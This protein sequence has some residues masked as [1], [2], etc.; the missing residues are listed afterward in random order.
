MTVRTIY[1]DPGR[2]AKSL[3]DMIPTRVLVKNRMQPL[4]I[5]WVVMIVIVA[6][7][8]ATAAGSDTAKPV[9]N[10]TLTPEETKWIEDH[11]FIRVSGPRAFPPFHFFEK[12]GALKGISADYLFLIM[13][14]LGIAVVAT[15][16]LPWPEVLEKARLKQIDLIACAAR[17]PE[18]E[19]YLNFSDSYLSF[20]LVIVSRKD[21]EFIG[22]IE[23]LYGKTLAVVQKNAVIEWLRQDGVKYL[24]YS[25]ST[26]LNGLEAVAF[27]RADA[28]IEN[29]AAASFLIEKHGL[30]NLKIAAPTPYGPYDLHMAVREDAPVLLGLINKALRSIPPE[31]RIQ[32][33][34]KW[35]SVRY[36][37]GTSRSEVFGWIA[38]ILIFSVSLLCLV[39]IWRRQLGQESLN[40]RKTEAALRNSEQNLLVSKQKLDLHFKHTPLAVIE[41]DLDFRVSSWNPAAEK[42]FGYSESQILG[43]QAA[44]LVHDEDKLIVDDVWSALLEQSGGSRSTNR[45]VTKQ[46][47]TIICE[48]FNAPVVDENGEIIAVFSL[49]LNVTRRKKAEQALE[50]TQ[51]LFKMITDH[52]S[53][54]VSIHDANGRFVYASPSFSRIGHDPG[55]L[56]GRSGFDIMVKEDI[57]AILNDMDV[58]RKD[59][60]NQTFLD[61]RLMDS[62][63][64]THYYRGAF[65]AVYDA[66]SNLEKIIC[67]GED[68]TELRTVQS[69]KVQALTLAAETNKYALVGQVAGKMAHDFNNILSAIMGNAELALLDSK[70][71]EM[72]ETFELILEQTMRGRNLT[73]NLVAF[74]KD[75]E[76]KQELFNLNDKI[77][78]V[79]SLMKKDLEGIKVVLKTRP[80]LPELLA[81]PGMIEHALVNILQNAIHAVSLS[82]DPR[83]VIRT[84]CE[85]DTVMII[86]EDNGC[87]I[88][89]KYL[90]AIFE[91]SFSLKGNKDISGVYE[92]RIKGTGYG[93]ANVKKYIEQHH[94]RIMVRSSLDSGTAFTIYLPIIKEALTIEEKQQIQENR[95]VCGR[96]ILI[97]EDEK[98]ISDIQRRTLSQSPCSH[99]VDVASDGRKAIALFDQGAYDLVS[100]DYILPGKVNGM[101]VY[102]HIR[103]TDKRL[104]V[105][106][107]SGNIE[108][109]ESI[110]EMKRNDSRIDHLSKPCQNKIYVNRISQMLERMSEKG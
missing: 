62:A 109:L 45:N 93:L 51:D 40:R 64:H 19:A 28:R 54:L 58:I 25:V 43:R 104:P 21:S 103:K 50:K 110:K 98:A 107:I 20:P 16:A 31:T 60:V 106:F 75:Q 61:Y 57:E 39:L 14:Q 63:G 34:S 74:A 48:W 95:P 29:L 41:W 5:F 59:Q 99:Q 9:L 17:V 13:E 55:E 80:D 23:D 90:Y 76:I 49:V 70:D 89:E 53:A 86:V 3:N 77:N 4:L 91:P 35:L 100:L 12:N 72:S 15:G 97:V 30:T 7:F 108:F 65:D 22:G 66:R 105:L 42:I 11:P 84:A 26:P 1:R 101:D 85:D 67:V 102:H 56:I 2:I 37:K 52:T 83:I 36:E 6:G 92:E 96:R 73:K 33:R 79:I 71:S 88:E 8:G 81:D 68:I 38:G 24:P 69:E 82:E 18:R 27:G 78:L 87:G 94:G 46:G 44:I 32:I 10:I 47:E